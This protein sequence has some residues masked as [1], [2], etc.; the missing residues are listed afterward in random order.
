MRNCS[1]T[2]VLSCALIWIVFFPVCLVVYTF[3]AAHMIFSSRKLELA[4]TA[5]TPMTMRW[6]Q[7][8][9]GLRRDEACAELI[10]VLP[11]HCYARYVLPR[12]PAI[13]PLLP[14]APNASAQGM[15]SAENLLLARRFLGRWH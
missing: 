15:K 8:Q 10:K 12:F 1:L 13:H 7:H 3:Y 14:A 2:A 5:L 9:L 11:N 4:A 6:L